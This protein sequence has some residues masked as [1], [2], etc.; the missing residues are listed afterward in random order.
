MHHVVEKALALRD[1]YGN[2]TASEYQSSSVPI[3]K[4]D[5]HSAYF[6][7][8]SILQKILEDRDFVRYPTRLEFDSKRIDPGLFAV[9]EPADAKD[10]S[11]G[12]IIYIHEHFKGRPGDVPALVLYHLV[13]VNYDD[14]ATSEEAELFGATALGMEKEEYYKLLCHLTDQIPR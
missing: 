13:A 7:D 11:Q 2:F 6:I 8:S 1:K 12:Y 9:A 4:I 5:A 14:M 3:S 10:P